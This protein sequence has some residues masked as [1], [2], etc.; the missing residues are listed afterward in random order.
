MFPIPGPFWITFPVNTPPTS[1]RRV[2]G[3]LGPDSGA[4]S[5][6]LIPFPPWD[7]VLFLPNYLLS[8]FPQVC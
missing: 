3:V 7:S 6:L 4:Q 1:C 2:V 8:M 5:L